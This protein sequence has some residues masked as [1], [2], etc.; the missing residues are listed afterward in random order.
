MCVFTP[1][2][3]TPTQQTADLAAIQTV[4]NNIATQQVPLSAQFN[5]DGYALLFEP[6]TY[7]SVATPLVFEVGYYTEVAGLGAV[8]QDTTIN[9]QID[10]F[11]NALDS[12]ARGRGTA[13]SRSA[14]RATGPTR[15]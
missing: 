1:P 12:R 9:G 15:P 2:S 7:G 10:V 4:V 14:K 11:P 5:N 8:P 13:I 3:G 6:G